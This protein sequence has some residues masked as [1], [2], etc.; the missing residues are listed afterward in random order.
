MVSKIKYNIFCLCPLHSVKTR[1]LQIG[2]STVK[3]N[4]ALRFYQKY[5]V[6]KL[7]GQRWQLDNGVTLT[8]EMF[9]Y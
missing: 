8:I 1:H 2:G 6:Y 4:T 3:F 5:D 9:T 7:N